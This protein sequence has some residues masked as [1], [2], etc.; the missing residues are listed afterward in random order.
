MFIFFYHTLGGYQVRSSVVNEL[1]QTNF[2]EGTIVAGY[3]QDI[4]HSLCAWKWFCG[5]G[6][7]ILG[8]WK[9]ADVKIGNPDVNRMLFIVA[10]WLSYMNLD[11]SIQQDKNAILVENT[12]WWFKT[13]VAS[14]VMIWILFPCS[15]MRLL[16]KLIDR[17]TDFWYWSAFTGL[18]FKCGEL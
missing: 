17:V 13:L 18:V 16:R 6:K 10:F 8:R 12:Y 14:Y 5:M 4:F 3:V 11:P 2:R 15:E 1:W 9:I 7:Q